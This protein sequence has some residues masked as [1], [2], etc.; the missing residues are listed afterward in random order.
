MLAVVFEFD[1]GDV[2]IQWAVTT[3][4]AVP[5]FAI[6]YGVN[7]AGF[8]LSTAAGRAAVRAW[9][10]AVAAEVRAGSWLP[11][12]F[13]HDAEPARRGTVAA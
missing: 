13:H 7:E 8:F 4:V 3:V 5:L 2:I 1:R 10:A 11:D 6:G 12:P 9:F